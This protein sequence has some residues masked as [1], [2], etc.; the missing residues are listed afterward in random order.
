MGKTKAAAGRPMSIDEFA[1]AIL[2]HYRTKDSKE[3]TLRAKRQ[4]LRILRDDFGVATT[5][6]LDDALARRFEAWAADLNPLN[7]IHKLS[8]FKSVCEVGVQLG[9]LQRTPR[10]A[11]IPHATNFAK[12]SRTAPPSEV[13]VQRII[14]HLRERSDQSWEDHRLFALVAI[15]GLTGMP[16]RDALRLRIEDVDTAENV[17]RIHKTRMGESFPR[18]ILIPPKVASILAGWLKQ[19]KSEWL[20]PSKD[21]A[22]PWEAHGW[23]KSQRPTDQLEAAARAAGVDELTF[24]KLRRFAKENREVATRGFDLATE[25]TGPHRSVSIGDR[26]VVVSSGDQ[27]RIIELLRHESPR[28]LSLDEIGRRVGVKSPRHVM[29]KLRKHPGLIVEET[30]PSGRKAYG[31]VYKR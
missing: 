23:N 1:E 20:F 21:R 12:G 8:M 18:S 13:G 17:I 27:A 14:D 31:I 7:R 22:A 24:E 10:L 5:S 6:G 9:L 15:V 19:S 26:E 3:S 25:T 30:R 29:S 2:D 28:L 16:Y 4:I 11:P